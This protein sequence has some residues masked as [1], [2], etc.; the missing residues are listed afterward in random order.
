MSICFFA[1][2]LSFNTFSKK[3]FSE[4]SKSYQTQW[5]KKYFV[6]RYI[7]CE[8]IL[9]LGSRIHKKEIDISSLTYCEQLWSLSFAI[10]ETGLNNDLVSRAKA[11]SSM[12]TYRK[13]APH[14]CKKKTC[15]LRYAGIYHATRNLRLFGPCDGAA[16]YNA[17]PSGSCKKKKKLGKNYAKV[18]LRVYN[19]LWEKEGLSCLHKE[20]KEEL[21][22]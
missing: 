22:K 16:K 6:K 8:D 5:V 11:K 9:H 15:D 3:D 17:G 18:V 2:I 10:V 13:Y 4:Y 14:G 19:K 12:Q 7:E 20:S 1:V 21:E